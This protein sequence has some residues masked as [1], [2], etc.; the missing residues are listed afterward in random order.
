MASLAPFDGDEEV[1]ISSELQKGMSPRVT[2]GNIAS[3]GA[4]RAN[5]EVEG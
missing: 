3:N 2:N 4:N 5:E 1:E